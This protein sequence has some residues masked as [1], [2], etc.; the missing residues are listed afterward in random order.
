M[1]LF[2]V[3]QAGAAASG[4]AAFLAGAIPNFFIHRFWTWQRC[5]PVGMRR[6]L[7]PYL[8][9]IT[10]SGLVA[11]GLT[12]GVD[13]LVGGVLRDHVVHTAVIAIVYGLSYLPLFVVKFALL[14]RLVFG[15]DDTV[16]RRRARDSRDQ[17]PTST[18]A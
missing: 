1:L 10:F 7:L 16:R 8:G 4:A 6:E 11:T 5:G 18:R 13:R 3:V 2:G 9:V 12:T 17:V 14:D 15:G